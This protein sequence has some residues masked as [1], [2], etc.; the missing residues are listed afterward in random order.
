MANLDMTDGVYR[1][2]YSGFL[3]NKKINRLSWMAEAWFWRLIV[4]ADD[5]GNLS[6]KWRVLAVDASPVRE[7]SIEE[8]KRLTA[9]VVAARLAF[10]YTVDGD[11]YLHITGFID[12]QPAGKNGRRIQ[13]IPMHPEE[14]GCIQ[15]NPGESGGIQEN[16]RESS[17]SE[18]T[19]ETTTETTTKPEKIQTQPVAALSGGDE[20]PKKKVKL[21]P[22]YSEAFL[23]FYKAYPSVRRQ[24]KQECWE[25]WCRDVKAH[26]QTE[27]V[28]EVLMEGLRRWCKCHQWTK[29]GGQYV[30]G[31]EV[32]LRRRMYL[33]QP[34]TAPAKEFE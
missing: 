11:E 8:A 12:K 13:R 24:K 16:P 29:D 14:S 15:G 4:L 1:R 25:I 33:D 21:I 32:F 30:C 34:P 10:V 20:K 3:G 28:V 5:Y 2:I 26:Q 27:K 9:E 31:S 22:D 6:L 23:E 17:P 19:N 7:L 18:T